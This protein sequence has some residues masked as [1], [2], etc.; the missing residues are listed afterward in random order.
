[1]MCLGLPGWCWSR[2][3]SISM[4]AGRCLTAMVE[5]LVS[6]AAEPEAERGDDPG[7][8]AAV[9]TVRRVR[10]EYPWRWGPGDVED[11]TTSLVS[12]PQRR[13]VSTVRGL[14]DDVA[15]VL[16]LLDRQAL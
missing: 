9:A 1:M 12:G 3:W 7:P 13:A 16:R 14:P 10:G 2:V 15:A 6:P 5:G 4:R 11:F 8:G